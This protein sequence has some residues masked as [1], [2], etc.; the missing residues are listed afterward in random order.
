MTDDV[1]TN[2]TADRG[3]LAFAARLTFPDSATQ[4]KVGGA[5][6]GPDIANQPK[7]V[8]SPS[9]LQKHPSSGSLSAEPGPRNVDDPI[10]GVI[11]PFAKTDVL[12]PLA[13]SPKESSSSSKTPVPADFPKPTSEA[14]VEAAPAP[15]NSSHDIRVRVPDNQGGVMDVRF[16]DLGSEVK[17]SVRTPDNNLA[18]T[19]RGNLSSLTQQLTAVGIQTET[20]RPASGS[21]FSQGSSQ[22]SADSDPNSN[23]SGHRSGR[24]AKQGNQRE[25]TNQNQNQ[26]RWLQEFEFSAGTQS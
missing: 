11:Q 23:G 7:A 20:W 12:A 21:S 5:S 22:Q 1:L 8:S 25:P 6:D 18:Q 17:V 2:L 19:L 13:G 16:L 24:D 4:T 15:A 9:V 14:N 26:P 10:K 3:N